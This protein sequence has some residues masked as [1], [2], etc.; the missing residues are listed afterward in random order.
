[1]DA[2]TIGIALGIILS[3]L[4]ATVRAYSKQSFELN[5]TVLIFLAT[6]SVPGG[7]ALIA[8]GFIGDASSLP[9]SWREHVT[10]AG[11]VAIGLAVHYVF[12]AFRDCRMSQ[13]KAGEQPSTEAEVEKQ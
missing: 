2:T 12:T 7:I 3:A 8:A 9:S 10:V 1:M 6:F 4:Y 5:H 13:S 11:I